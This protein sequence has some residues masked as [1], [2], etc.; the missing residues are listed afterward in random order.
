MNKHEASPDAS[1]AEAVHQLIL[2]ANTS[3]ASDI[4]IEPLRDYCRIRFR[5]DSLL[6]EHAT[7]PAW[8]GTRMIT[9]IKLL[10]ELNIAE[11]RL[12]QDGRLF[13]ALTPGQAL[14][15]RVST[16]PHHLGEKIVLRLFN[17]AAQ[18]VTLANCG[19][20]ESQLAIVQTAMQAQSGLILMTGP[21]GSG[22]TTTLYAA[23]HALNTVTHNIITIEDPIEMEL[24]GITQV[25]VHPRIG[26]NF[27]NALRAFLRQDPDIL[28]IGEIRDP[29]TASIAL[30]AAQTGHL[31]LASLHTINTASA[32]ARLASLGLDQPSTQASLRLV[33]A[34]RLLR[35]PC[36]HCLSAGCSACHQGYFGQTG[37]FEC[38]QPALETRPAL[39]LA[40]A[41]FIKC[42]RGETTLAECERVLGRSHV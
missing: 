11:T 31:V 24:N 13:H 6:H 9:H 32:L 30:Q 3:R 12:P 37:V 8:Q 7:L 19:L 34:Q 4:H 2:A 25:N 10:A 27:A 38:Y 29:E 22:K 41:A 35:Q 33:V 40:Q 5:I 15:L 17:H 21:T 14:S 28:L 23:L 39:T 16:C 1:T 36:R 18:A 20:L 26:L 42:E